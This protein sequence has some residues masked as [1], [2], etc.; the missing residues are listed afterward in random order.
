MQVVPKPRDEKKMKR[1]RS[2]GNGIRNDNPV[3]QFIFSATGAEFP[4]LPA[5][6]SPARRNSAGRR[7]VGSPHDGTDFPQND[8]TAGTVWR[9]D[10]GGRR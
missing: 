2:E 7:Q 1:N 6:P 3:G 4:R 5:D 10:R 9:E 8:D